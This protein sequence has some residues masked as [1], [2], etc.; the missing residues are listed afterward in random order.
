MNINNPSIQPGERVSIVKFRVWLL[1]AA[2]CLAFF[3]PVTREL[4][5]VAVIGFFV[6]VFSWEAGSHRYFSHRSFKTTRAFQLF[7]AVLSAASAQRGPI[8]WATHHRRHHRFS[9]KKGDPHSPIQQGF[10]HAH[11]GW[12]FDQDKLSTD[13]NDAK[14]LSRYPEL[15]F[16]NKYHYVFPYAVLTAF[17]VLGH[18]TSLFGRTGIGI[19]AAIWGFFVPTLL[20][21]HSTFLVNTITHGQPIKWIRSRRFSTSDASCN[22]WI[23]SIPTMGASWHNNHHR[24]MNSARAG[25]YWWEMDLTFYVLKALSVLGIVWDLNEVPKKV[26]QE[27][28]MPSST[29]DIEYVE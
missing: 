5:L 21:L 10:W 20:S 28:S 1:H 27:T 22:S 8:W 14:D 25:F 3:I 18:F 12:L 7:L 19:S 26:L 6:R 24:Y 13:L 9:D 23:F 17:F 4:V 11:M 2:S 16:I 29:N 15:V